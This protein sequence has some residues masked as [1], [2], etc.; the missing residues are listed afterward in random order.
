MRLVNGNGASE[1][2]ATR[3]PKRPPL[4][5]AATISAS[6]KLSS[7]MLVTDG[8]EAERSDRLKLMNE[9]LDSVVTSGIATGWEA[10]ATVAASA[11]LRLPERLPDGD[12]PVAAAGAAAAPADVAPVE[13][14][15]V[16]VGLIAIAVPSGAVLTAVGLELTS[17][18]SPVAPEPPEVASGELIA[19]EKAGPVSPVLVDDDPARAS[20]ELPE[21]AVGDALT[22]ESPPEPASEPP[23]PTLDPPVLEV[24]ACAGEASRNSAPTA[25]RARRTI[26][27]R[28]L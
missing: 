7:A 24:W 16:C 5:V 1:N 28:V 18:E 20:P 23:V 19:S 3:R 6:A 12:E 2:T 27:F 4:T 8:P 10:A 11:A 17:P 13:P 26:D 14:D 21:I 15:A 25:A 22:E 9:P